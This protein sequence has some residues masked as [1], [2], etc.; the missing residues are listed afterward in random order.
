MN[1]LVSATVAARVDVSQY[2]SDVSSFK[3]AHKFLPR[4]QGKYKDENPRQ[5]F[6]RLVKMWELHQVRRSYQKCLLNAAPCMCV[7]AS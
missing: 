2:S 4:L 5:L 3:V 1:H 6:E 7:P